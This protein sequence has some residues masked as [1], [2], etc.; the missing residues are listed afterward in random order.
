MKRRLLDFLN[1]CFNRDIDLRI[2]IFN[3][4][5]VVGCVGS[6]ITGLSSAFTGGEYVTVVLC[7][8]ASVFSALLIYFASRTQKYQLC[9]FITVVGI[10]IGLFSYLFFLSG[11][12][13]GSIPVFFVFAVVLT[14]FMLEGKIAIYTTLLELAVYSGLYLYAFLYP[15]SVVPYPDESGYFFNHLSDLLIVCLGLGATMYAQVR[16]YR[17]QQRRVNEQNAVLAQISLAKT[18]FLANA[19]HEMRTPL[20]VVSVNIQMV[21]GLLKQI[22]NTTVDSEAQTLLQD[23]QAE[24]MRLSRM[25]EGMLSLNV[26]SESTEKKKTDY[27]TLLNSSV[28]MMRLL[29]S[30]QNNSIEADIA[31]RL[32]VFGNSDLLSQ[33][34]INLL[35]NSNAHTSNDTIRLAAIRNGGE[36]SVEVRDNGS[37]ISSALLPHV[38]ER[39]VSDGGTGVGLFLCKTVVEAHGGT[40][41]IE[42]TEGIGTTVSFILPVYQGQL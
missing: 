4:L 1:F 19:S 14:V 3:I 23:A 36:I 38:F 30:K 34:I 26:I 10:F 27:S 16:L 20:T 17:E 37:G 11:G 39:G 9:Y 6:F 21:M 7:F 18:Q 25:V 15:Q 41:Q 32:T 33:V 28:N 2:R 35:Q 13:Y 31:D 8:A 22:D 24:I 5:A 12:Y 40:I 29:L 42:S